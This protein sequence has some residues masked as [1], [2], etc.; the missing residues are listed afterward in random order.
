VAIIHQATL[1]PSKLELLST[2][3]ATVSG[4]SKYVDPDLSQIGAYRFDD[5]AGEVG[6]ETHILSAADGAVLQIPLT[7]RNDQIDGLDD[8]LVGIMEHSVLGRRWVYNGCADSVYVGELLRV[9]ELGGSE[10]ADVVETPDGPV[11][12]DALVSVRGSGASPTAT[13]VTSAHVEAVE[14]TTEITVNGSSSTELRVV[15]RHLLTSD[16]SG[17]S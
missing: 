7:Y 10:A 2:Y 6:I 17:S 1:S 9:I 4:L 5:P 16:L 12:R 14:E 11:R 8:Q 15:V 3:L 13:T